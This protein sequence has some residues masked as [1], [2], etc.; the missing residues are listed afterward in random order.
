M[1]RLVLS[2]GRRDPE[3]QRAQRSRL[4]RALL[5]VTGLVTIAASL[6]PWIVADTEEGPVIVLGVERY[7]FI[8]L[9]LGVLLVVVAL[10]PPGPLGPVRRWTAIVASILITVSALWDPTNVYQ[11]VNGDYVRGTIQPA[12]W[13]TA[14]TGLAAL[15][16]GLLIP[17][18]PPARPDLP[19]WPVRPRPTLGR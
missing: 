6:Q 9:L 3:G 7:G 2:G 16:G 19:P 15:V 8:T 13:V 14:A 1:A 5:A 12:L 10:L 18:L 11:L 17:P 4:G